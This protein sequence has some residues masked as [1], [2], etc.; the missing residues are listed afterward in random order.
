MVKCESKDDRGQ[1][2]ANILTTCVNRVL[3]MN[4][5]ES[6]DAANFQEM[7]ASGRPIY[8][9]RWD[10]RDGIE[11]IDVRFRI[12]T[13]PLFTTNP[14]IVDYDLDN[15]HRATEIHDTDLGSI[16]MQFANG[17]YER[18]QQIESEYIRYQGSELQKSSYQH[19][20]HHELKVAD[21]M[22]TPQL[23]HRQVQRM[24]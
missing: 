12:V 3:R 16:V 8:K 9:L 6:K 18:G 23:L 17:D 1:E 21:K 10:S 14:G 2:L 7:L 5:S 4:E 22:S 24:S 11:P 13:M 20:Y 15:L 19:P